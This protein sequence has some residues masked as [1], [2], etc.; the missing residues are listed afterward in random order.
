M[1]DSLIYLIYMQLPIEIISDYVPFWF[2]YI[3]IEPIR[4]KYK[5][6]RIFKSEDIITYEVKTWRL[7]FN[8]HRIYLIDEI[9]IIIVIVT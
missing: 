2:S 3:E 6:F 5:M 8:A 4:K 9:V 7:L 1:S